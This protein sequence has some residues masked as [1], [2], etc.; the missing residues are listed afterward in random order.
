MS[1]HNICVEQKYEKY[2]IF[3]IWKFSFLGG[4]VFNIFELACFRNEYGEFERLKL[5]VK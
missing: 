4:K 5:F 3:F 2:Q 1:T